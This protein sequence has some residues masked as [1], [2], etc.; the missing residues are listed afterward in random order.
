MVYQ[1][2]AVA[3]GTALTV[4]VTTGA[5]TELGRIGKLAAPGTSGRR[6]NAGSTHSDTD[7]SGSRWAWAR[8]SLRWPL[9]G[10]C[11]SVK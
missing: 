8:L 4:I 7:W 9:F 1:G 10:G 3:T 11:R 2:T 6:S 5:R